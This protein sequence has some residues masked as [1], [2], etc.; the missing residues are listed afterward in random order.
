MYTVQNTY[1][2]FAHITLEEYQELAC[3]QDM[4]WQFPLSVFVLKAEATNLTPRLVPL[5]VR[6]QVKSM[7]AR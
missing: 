1:G 4:L 2:A 5:I 6:A 3:T 7:I